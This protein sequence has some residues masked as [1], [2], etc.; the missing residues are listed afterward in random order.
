MNKKELQALRRPFIRELFRDSDIIGRS[1]GNRFIIFVKGMSD[2]AKVTEK[3]EQICRMINNHY[4]SDA[5]TISVFGKVGISCFPMDG[6]TYDD[7][8]SASLKALYFAKHNVKCNVAFAA[9]AAGT[10]RLLHE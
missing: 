1:S 8:Y 10:T 9:E 2:R 7:L 3:A 6:S 5:G 4:Q